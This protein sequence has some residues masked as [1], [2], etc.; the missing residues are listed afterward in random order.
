MRQFGAA[1]PPQSGR[2]RGG[3]VVEVHVIV[4]ALLMRLQLEIAKHDAY[5]MSR[6]SAKVPDA[7]LEQHN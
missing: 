3:T 7:V 4:G 6:S 2:F 5:S 1:E